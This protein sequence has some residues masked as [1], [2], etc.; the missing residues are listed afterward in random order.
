MLEAYEQLGLAEGSLVVFTADHGE[1]MM[2][3][4][5][6]FTHGYQVYEEIARV[7]LLLRGAGIQPNRISHPVSL[8]DLAPTLLRAAGLDPPEGIYGRPLG[9]TAPD[10][11]VFSEA[12]RRGYLWRAMW[13]GKSKWMV[14]VNVAQNRSERWMHRAANWGRIELTPD[15]EQHRYYDLETDPAE[16]QP[17][18]WTSRNT[19]ARLLELARTDRSVWD[20]PMYSG[21]RI[22]AP[23]VAPGVEAETLKKLKSLGYVQ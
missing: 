12:F 10:R 8:A 14:R 3:H 21:R 23:K 18:S 9:E 22:D 16:L 1:S 7:P 4:E 20:F 19:P 6:W 17:A 2:E 5:R 15:L 13:R 11:E